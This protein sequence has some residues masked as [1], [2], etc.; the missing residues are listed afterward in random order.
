MRFFVCQEEAN[1]IMFFHASRNRDD[2]M[3]NCGIATETV[4]EEVCSV[5]NYATVS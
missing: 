2:E 4:G 5:I 3:L 1:R